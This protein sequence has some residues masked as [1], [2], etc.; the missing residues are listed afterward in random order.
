MG[1]FRAP[2]GDTMVI[3]TVTRIE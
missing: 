1:D 3:A 2:N